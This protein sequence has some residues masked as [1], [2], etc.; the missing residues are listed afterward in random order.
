MKVNGE[1]KF[2]A[3]IPLIDHHVIYDDET[4]LWIHLQL[5]DVFSYF[6]TRE[7]SSQEC[8]NWEDYEVIFLTPDLAA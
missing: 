7:L 3:S 5:K 2:H 8:E 1:I 6:P 4:K